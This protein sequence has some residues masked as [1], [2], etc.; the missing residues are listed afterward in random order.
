MRENL[1]Y[2]ADEDESSV[3]NSIR[4]VLNRLS[5]SARASFFEN[6]AGVHV[7][8]SISRE[9]LTT[10]ESASE[11][12]LIG[13]AGEPDPNTT[14]NLSDRAGGG[15]VDLYVEDEDKAV[16]IEIK[17][18][19]SLSKSQLERYA[20]A[21][22]ATDVASV[23]WTDIYRAL[24]DLESEVHPKRQFLID[25]MLDY[26]NALKLHQESVTFEHYW[27][28]QDGYKYVRVTSDHVSFY[29]NDY[30]ERGE[31]DRREL[32]WDQFRHLFEDIEKRHGKEVI[33]NIF[34]EITPIS[35]LFDSFTIIGEIQ[36]IRTDDNL[37]RLF[38]DETDESIK[39]REIQSDDTSPPAPGSPAGPSETYAWLM[40][41]SDQRG[42]FSEHAPEVLEQIFL[43]CEWDASL[44]G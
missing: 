39:L 29:T 31:T 8:G 22:D 34:I 2:R 20:T 11:T 41:D 17:L 42:M 9:K 19:D 36:S 38:Y 15:P 32:S 30:Q 43:Q 18:G 27:G 26:L 21:L 6:L 40:N 5:P 1:L 10:A 33:Q 7:E 4:N 3:A 37:L 14:K 28:E 25:D 23:T 35:D 24:Q 16:A 12:V 13:L 44:A